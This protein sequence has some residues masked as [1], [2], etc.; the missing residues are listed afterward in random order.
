ME[1]PLACKPG[2]KRKRKTPGVQ[3]GGNPNA[4]PQRICMCAMWCACACSVGGAMAR[5]TAPHPDHPYG[6]CGT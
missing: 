6:V 2:A 1:R 5:A 3:A 4:V